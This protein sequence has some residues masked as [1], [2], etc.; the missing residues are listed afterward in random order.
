MEIDT[1][2][3][4]SN[5]IDM[6]DV[7]L[8]NQS[9]TAGKNNIL[10]VDSRDSV[11]H[12][13]KIC[14]DSSFAIPGYDL[15]DKFRNMINNNIKCVYLLE[16][17]KMNELALYFINRGISVS[18]IKDI[19]NKAILKM[20]RKEIERTIQKESISYYK[21][22]YLQ[23]CNDTDFSAYPHVLENKIRELFKMLDFAGI[24]HNE[25]ERINFDR[26]LQEMLA[27]TNQYYELAIYPLV[28]WCFIT[29]LA[30]H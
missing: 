24:E 30:N 15:T 2:E 5:N 14:Y 12:L 22:Q 28:K 27:L 9:L 23:W 1:I 26:W 18:I 29:Q 3:M 11:F 25:M 7:M 10:I 13:K 6:I 17:D 20:N 19:D 21:Y 16:H 4:L 8:L